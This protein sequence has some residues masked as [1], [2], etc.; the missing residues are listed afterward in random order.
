ML[1]QFID[2]GIDVEQVAPGV[3][4]PKDW[5]QELKSHP[6]LESSLTEVA[7]AI[8]AATGTPWIIS[9]LSKSLAGEDRSES[10]SHMAGVAGD[11]APM[12]SVDVILPEDPPLSCLAM[13]WQFL[14]ILHPIL[15]NLAPASVVEGDHI[16]VLATE[17]PVELSSCTLA[18]PTIS[19]AYE[20]SKAVS[21]QPIPLLF[22]GVDLS[23]GPVTKINGRQVT[24]E[25]VL[26]QLA[27]IQDQIMQ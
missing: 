20:L 14:R 10:Q 2:S 22:N 23:L 27:E 5:K 11:I 21:S 17:K 6:R 26:Q 18:V 9:S 25:Q 4:I 1:V 7:S 12:Y 24:G 13:N 8:A 16:H 3:V 15:A 19:S